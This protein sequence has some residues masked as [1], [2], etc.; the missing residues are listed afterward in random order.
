MCFLWEYA[1]FVCVVCTH[2]GSTCV[3]GQRMT[4]DVLF[5]SPPYFL[6]GEPGVQNRLAGWLIFELQKFVWCGV[7]IYIYYI[8]WCVHVDQRTFVGSEFSFTVW[9]LENKLR[10]WFGCKCSYW[11]KSVVLIIIYY[12]RICLWR[13]L[14]ITM[15]SEV[16]KFFFIIFCDKFASVT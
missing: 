6:R 8:C 2:V 15:L 11:L 4:S 12:F 13:N 1:L 5:T 9:V 3:G 14:A 10:F 16:G 7:H